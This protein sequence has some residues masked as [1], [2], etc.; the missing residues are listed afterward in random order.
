MCVPV[1]SHIS[2]TSEA[3]DITFDTVTASVTRMHHMLIILTLTL[4]QGRTDLNHENNE[5]SIILETVQAL[6]IKFVVKLVRLKVYIFFS[7]SDGLDLHSRSQLRLKLEK[8]LT[9]IIIVISR[10]IFKLWHLNL[11]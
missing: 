10:I 4:I 11:A 3:I 2:E 7:Q 6:P 9:H 1:A 5:C 8:F